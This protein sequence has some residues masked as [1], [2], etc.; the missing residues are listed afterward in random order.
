MA[1]ML[2]WR[3][4]IA[5]PKLEKAK[6]RDREFYSGQIK[7]AEYFINSILPV[8]TGKLIAIADSSPAVVEIS[9]EAFGGL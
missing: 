7:T 3:A 1:W 9:E 8:T 2:L 4:A 6:S 5:A